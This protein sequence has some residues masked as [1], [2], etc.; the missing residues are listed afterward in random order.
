MYHVSLAVQCIYGWSDEEGKD[1]DER[2][3]NELF[4]GWER[5]EIAL[6]LVCR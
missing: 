3:G 2:E 4:G 5:M 6:P 1:G